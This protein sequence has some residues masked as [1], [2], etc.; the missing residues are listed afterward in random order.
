[1]NRSREMDE[2]RQRGSSITKTLTG[3]SGER[4]F[5]LDYIGR[6][7]WTPASE[8]VVHLEG[9]VTLY[10]QPWNI[11]VPQLERYV[12]PERSCQWEGQREVIQQSMRWSILGTFQDIKILPTHIIRPFRCYCALDQIP[13]AIVA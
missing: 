10:T 5:F 3:T 2:V 4:F 1:M 7:H 13:H 12:R 6:G 8:D 11:D 9:H